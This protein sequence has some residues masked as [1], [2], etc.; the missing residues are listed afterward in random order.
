MNDKIILY[1]SNWLY[2]A[3]VIG[4]S[5]YKPNFCSFSE[6]YVEISKNLFSNI[7]LLND[8]F[9]SER[10]INLKGKNDI[11]PN[12]ID[13]SGNQTRVFIDFIQSFEEHLSGDGFCNICSTPYYLNKDRL[14]T[15][16]QTH[17]DNAEGFFSKIKKF[18]MVYN[19][20]LGA[21]FKKFPN[22]F[23]GMQQSLEVCHLCSFILL[24]HHLSFTKLSDN[25][26]IFINAPSFK[27]MYELNRLF[28]AI[29][30]TRNANDRLSIR[31]ILAMSII[32]YALKI[33]VTLGY[34]ASVNIEV[35]IKTKDNIDF[36]SL[37][38]EVM[39]IISDKQ[40]A[41]L[42]SEIGETS[43]LKLILSQKYSELTDYAYKIL[44]ISLKKDE[45]LQDFE[46][47][48]LKYLIKLKKNINM[49]TD[50]A[51]KL[52]KLYTLIEEK[53]KGVEV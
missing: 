49:K 27:V 26:Q 53:L 8:Y 28:R 44:R 31:E 43:I 33:P 40:I 19:R 41:Y 16:N 9:N 32:D 4:L 21:S 34:W 11:Y 51:N 1:P 10:I 29:Y 42:L 39:R 46:K 15:L 7:D 37:P 50:F 38:D 22:G 2:N 17:L 14:N 5:L 3:G 6:N 45:E 12:F 30:E 18:D 25:S 20:L 52:L 47:S 48:Y 23:W 35:I 36:F 13:T 24:H